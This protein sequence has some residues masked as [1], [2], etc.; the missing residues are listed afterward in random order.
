MSGHCYP[1][2]RLP[3][4]RREYRKHIGGASAGRLTD[5]SQ[6]PS[7]GTQSVISP[8]RSAEGFGNST[9]ISAWSRTRGPTFQQGRRG[10]NLRRATCVRSPGGGGEAN[11]DGR[12]AGCLPDV[13][14]L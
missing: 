10:I 9:L 11:G 14:C 5:F 12:T 6:P 2:K 8:A 4:F 3:A 1:P 7:A 13:L